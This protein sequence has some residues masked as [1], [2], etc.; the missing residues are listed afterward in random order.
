MSAN[1][2]P[3]WSLIV[4]AGD[5]PEEVRAFVAKLA[6]VVAEAA[7]TAGLTL[8]NTQVEGAAACPRS[9]TLTLTG[10]APTALGGW[11]G[12]HLLIHSARGPRARRRWFAGVS[13]SP[14]PPPA[15]TELR[16]EDVLFTASRAGGPGGQHVNKTASAVRAVHTPSGLQVRASASRRQKDNRREALARLGALQR[17]AHQTQ[18]QT[19]HAQTRLGHHQL[20][21]GAPVRSWTLDPTGELRGGSADA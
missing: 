8:L 7:Q 6:V 16:P 10:D 9:I 14:A 17:E 18:T 13:L 1:P 19:T 21:R 11:C 2:T 12:T 3:R 5:G 15:P 20:I 4:S